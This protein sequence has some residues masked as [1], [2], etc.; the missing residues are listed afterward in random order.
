MWTSHLAP[1]LLISG[2]VNT[3][4]YLLALASFIPDI[5]W[6]GLSVLGVERISHSEHHAERCFPYTASF[7]YSHSLVGILAIA[8]GFATLAVSRVGGGARAWAGL[9]AATVSHWVLDILVHRNDMPLTP[10]ANSRTYGAGLFDLP[11][12]MFFLLDYGILGAAL[13]FYAGSRPNGVKKAGVLA[14]AGAALQAVFTFVGAPGTEARWVHAPLLMMQLAGMI[15]GVGMLEGEL[16]RGGMGNGTAAAQ[17]R[18]MEGNFVRGT[19][20][21]NEKAAMRGEEVPIRQE[22]PVQQE[23]HD[24]K[25]YSSKDG[26]PREYEYVRRDS[27]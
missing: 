6:L 1:A 2:L 10:F 8:A 23:E 14:V 11:P 5:L 4:V 19:E 24:E 26:L 15:W 16:G 27:L 7:P 17:G 22:R 25:Q 20:R 13:S 12:W 9:A 18:V 21:A 3:P